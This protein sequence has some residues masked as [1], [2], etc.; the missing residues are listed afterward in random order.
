[1]FLVWLQ[2]VSERENTWELAALTDEDRG[3]SALASLL[4]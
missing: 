2:N 4:C 1:M 3:N